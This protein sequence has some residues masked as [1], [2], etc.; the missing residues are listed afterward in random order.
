MPLI[1]LCRLY[2]DD[3][4]HLAVGRVRQVADAIV[5][6]GRALVRAMGRLRLAISAKSVAVASSD[7]VA[8]W[9]AE[10]LR[11]SGVSVKRDRSARDL[12][13]VRPWAAQEYHFASEEVSR[14]LQ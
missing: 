6:A 8:T 11:G 10:L 4:G 7:K 13:I 2:V 12:G 1:L 5:E 14:C 9:I 3:V